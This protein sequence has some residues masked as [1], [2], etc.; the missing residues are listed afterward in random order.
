V[1]L[2]GANDEVDLMWQQAQHI[3]L[4]A[5]DVDG[6]LTDGR[7]WLDQHGNEM[8]TFH[9]HDGQGIVLAHR[10]GL[11]TAWIS[12]RESAAVRRRAAELGVTGVFEKIAA[13]ASVMRELMQQTQLPPAAIAYIADDL[14]DVPV[15]R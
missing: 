6:V 1:Y 10:A 2:T 14:I 9:V 5:M 8:K 4:L 3:R 11:Q 13:K 7:M 12:G 15:F